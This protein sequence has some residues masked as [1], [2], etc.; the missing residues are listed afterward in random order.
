MTSGSKATTVNKHD[1]SSSLALVHVD[2][3]QLEP[4]PLSVA[5]IVSSYNEKIRPVLDALENLRRLNIAKEGIQLPTIVVVGDQSSGKSS[6]LESLAGISLPRGQDKSIVGIP[7]LAEKLVHVQAMSI[8]KT[9]PEMI[10][11]INEK[12]TN[13]LH[14]LEILPA[15]LSSLADAMSAFLQIISLSRDSLRKILLIGE[16]EEYPEEKQMHCT[17]RLVDM[18]NSYASELRNCAESNATKDFLMEEI[19]VLE[20][21]K[22]IALPNFM[23]R[24]AFQTLLQRKVRGISHMPIDFVDSVWDYL[25]NVVTSVLNRHSANYYQ[26]QVSIRRAAE[27]LI[28]K[29]KHNCTQHVLRAVEMEKLTDYTC[30]PEYLVEYNKLLSSREAFLRE[31]LNVYRMTSTVNL[32]GVGDIEVNHLKKYPNMLTQAYDLKAQLI[33]YWNIV[34][35]RLTDVIALHLMLSINELVNVDFQKELCNGLLSSA[36]GG[37]ERLLEESPSIS[38]KREKLSRSVKVLRASKETVANIMDR[39]GVYGDN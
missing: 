19:N 28:A 31:V 27:N 3:D 9:L 29:K 5:P 15:N 20:E 35:K 4:Q 18:L 32:E 23:A 7:V 24:T 33:A 11:K 10:R 13:N 6:V 36:G 8:S 2:V 26:L 39:I 17:A 1:E 38:G 16:F 34:L 14:E 21:A 12:L 25:Q 37:V 30:D 22:F